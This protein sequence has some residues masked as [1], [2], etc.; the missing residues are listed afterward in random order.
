[1]YHLPFTLSTGFMIFLFLRSGST[2]ICCRIPIQSAKHSDEPLKANIM[3]AKASIMFWVSS[4]LPQMNWNPT[5]YPGGTS[6]KP[7]KIDLIWVLTEH[8]I[9]DLLA[10]LT[11]LYCVGRDLMAAP[12][13]SANFGS[14]CLKMI[15]F[16]LSGT[17][18][19]LPANLG[20]W[21]FEDDMFFTFRDCAVFAREF[22]D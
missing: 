14:G 3:S 6:L 1:M 12:F 18:L 11:I 9:K 13:S 5:A 20:I 15:C 7:L 2:R 10:S 22:W 4:P 17:V 19:F 16:L 21:L 8:T